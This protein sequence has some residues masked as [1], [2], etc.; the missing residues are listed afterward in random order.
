MKGL[1]WQIRDTRGTDTHSTEDG[2][3]LSRVETVGDGGNV[4]AVR[5]HVFGEGTVNGEARVLAL[6]A[7]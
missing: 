7:D 3:S 2:C 5:L 4:T 6:G 1:R